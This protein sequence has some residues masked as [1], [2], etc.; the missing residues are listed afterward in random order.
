MSQA[1]IDALQA[2]TCYRHT[3]TGFTV[4]ETH[5]SWVILTG[6]YA[7]KIKKPVNVGCLDYSTL[8]QR[9][10]FCE[11]EISRNQHFNSH[12]Y[13]GIVPI[14]GT[15]EAP[16]VDDDSAP[17]EY[18]VKMRQFD[19][20]NRLCQ[21]QQRGELTTDHIEGLI[22]QLADAHQCAEKAPAERDADHLE[23]IKTPVQNNFTQIAPLLEDEQDQQQLKLLESWAGDTADS[24]AERLSQRRAQGMIRACHGDLHLSNTVAQADQ[25][26]LL[27][28]IQCNPTL[29]WIDPINDLAFLLMD[30]ESRELNT[31]AN[32]ALNLYLELTGDYD[33]LALLPYYKSYRAMSRAKVCLLR[34]KEEADQLDA[35]DRAGILRQYRTYSALAER[36]IDFHMPYLLVTHGVS[37]SGKSTLTRYVVEAL[38]AIRIRSDVERKRL[39][40]LAP[41]DASPPKLDSDMYTQEATAHT[42]ERLASLGASCLKCAVPVIFDA[43]GLKRS[44]RDQLRAVGE[45]LGVPVVTINMAASEATL[46]RRIVKRQTQGDQVAEADLTILERQLAAREPLE[47]DELQSTVHVDTDAPGASQTLVQLLKDHLHLEDR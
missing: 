35:E 7:Y 21:L 18:A 6:D 20:R 47:E 43:T 28:C 36:Y 8:A 10:H 37:G 29:Y 25:V 1:L 9:R 23:A 17:F 44:Q 30:L 34:L 24:L 39:F 40:G 3:T 46:R 33:G 11:L 14:S 27:D 4:R 41:N 31:L 38:G 2:P 26:M 5:L 32:V 16:R 13:V 22:K 12:T 42:Y 19:D 15:L 45:G